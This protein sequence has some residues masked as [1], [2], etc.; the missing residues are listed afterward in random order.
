[1]VSSQS[2]NIRNTNARSC[3]SCFQSTSL[4]TTLDPARLGSSNRSRNKSLQSAPSGFSYIN[5]LSS[6]HVFAQLD[7]AGRSSEYART[8]CRIY[9]SAVDVEQDLLLLGFG[10]IWIG[11][12]EMPVI[13][14]EGPEGSWVY[15]CPRYYLIE[16]IRSPSLSLE[17]EH[18]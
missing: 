4:G 17:V 2:R 5:V 11:L 12:G 3:T 7:S 1:M 16:V 14:P 13:R 6:L 10:E 15:S 9:I 8:R 18:T